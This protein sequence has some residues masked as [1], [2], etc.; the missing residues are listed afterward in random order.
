MLY[1]DATLKDIFAQIL[2]RISTSTEKD[3]QQR[4]T[5]GA[6]LIAQTSTH[7]LYGAVLSLE[8]IW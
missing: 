8:E 6:A 7:K 2:F 5:I 1:H 3:E 4:I